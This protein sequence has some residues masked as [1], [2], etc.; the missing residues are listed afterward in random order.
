MR[1]TRAGRHISGAERLSEPSAAPDLARALVARALEHPRGVP[2]DIHLTVRAVDPAQLTHLTALPVTVIPTTTPAAA[3]AEV[4]RLLSPGV[5]AALLNVVD[6]PGALLVDVHGR[7][8]G[9]VVRVSSLDWA[10]HP[11]EAQKQHAS[12]ALALATKVASHPFIRG[13][14][15]ISDDPDYTTGYVA[16][17]EL[18]Y[19]RIPAMKEPGDPRGGRVFVYDGPADGIDETVRYLSETPTVIHE[20]A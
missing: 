10:H 15:C 11:T 19:V 9:P 12:E 13:E 2:D 3:H 14:A 6:L 16:S 4:A 8:L 20:R 1:A 5:L 17:A 18:G 7:P